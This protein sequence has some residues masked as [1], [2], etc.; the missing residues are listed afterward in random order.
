MCD[1]CMSLKPDKT[2]GKELSV[3]CP[4]CVEENITVA[5]VDTEWIDNG[6]KATVT[7]ND[8][9]TSTS[10]KQITTLKWGGGHSK[11]KQEK[12]QKEEVTRKHVLKRKQCK[13]GDSCSRPDCFFGHPRDE[14]VQSNRNSSSTY[15][16]GSGSSSGYGNSKGSNFKEYQLSQS[17]RA[18]EF[19][20]VPK[21]K[22][23]KF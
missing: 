23:M 17:E 4:L 13:F 16:H 21:N 14:G 18:P 9:R 7:V 11:K 10:T 20:A 2:P 19:D 12:K 15:G 1:S 22:K 8:D 3:R 6:K 5:A